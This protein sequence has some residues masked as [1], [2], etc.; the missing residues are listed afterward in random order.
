MILHV[1]TS[2]FFLIHFISSNVPN[3]FI[4]HLLYLFRQLIF[5]LFFIPSLFTI[6]YL[7]KGKTHAL[8]LIWFLSTK[9]PQTRD[10]YKC[11]S[12]N[13]ILL[14]RPVVAYQRDTNSPPII[15]AIHIKINFLTTGYNWVGTLVGNKGK[16]QAVMG[17]F[18]PC[19]G[20][21]CPVFLL[22]L[23]TFLF[24]FYLWTLFQ[25]VNLIY[26]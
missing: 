15:I 22:F 14:A 1:V 8:I 18:F 7:W 4:L 11:F 2:T 9:L 3:S 21:I 16:F 13:K 6:Y 10:K 26:F 20:S 24:I 17:R 19:P 25:F 12:W 23:F 5:L